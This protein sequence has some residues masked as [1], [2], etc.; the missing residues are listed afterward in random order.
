M[1]RLG[2][3]QQSSVRRPVARQPAPSADVVRFATH[4]SSQRRLGLASPCL[5]VSVVVFVLPLA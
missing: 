4:A 3:G 2:V 5:C 1:G